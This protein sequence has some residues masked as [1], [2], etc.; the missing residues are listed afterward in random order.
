[1]NVYF[2]SLIFVL[3]F[4]TISFG[5]TMSARIRLRNRMQEIMS[6]FIE[7]HKLGYKIARQKLGLTPKFLVLENILSL[8]KLGKTGILL[9]K[10]K[11][12][13]DEGPFEGSL[14]IKEFSSPEE[15]QK[16]VQINDWLMRRIQNNPRV[17]IPQIFSAGGNF[18]VYEGID[19][20]SFQESTLQPLIKLRLAGNALATFHTPYSSPVNFNRYYGLLLKMIQGLPISEDRKHKLQSFGLSFLY[21]YQ[22][23]YS[24]VNSYGDFHPGNIMLSDDGETAYLI[25]PEFVEGDIGADR[26]E[27]VSNFFVFDAYMEFLNKES[28]NTTFEQINLFLDSYNQFL[29]HYDTSLEQIY[30][31]THWLAMLFHL[32]LVSLLKG[33]VVVQSMK[34]MDSFDIIDPESHGVEEIIQSYRLC[35]YIWNMGI[36]YLPK[37]AFPRTMPPQPTED[38]YLLTWPI[39]GN[40]VLDM[41]RHDSLLKFAF[42]FPVSEEQMTLERALSLFHLK[43]KKTLSNK[44]KDLNNLVKIDI[45]DINSK[46]LVVLKSDWKQLLGIPLH[47]DANWEATAKIL[48][49]FWRKNPINMLVSVLS[50]FHSVSITE[51][52]NSKIFDKKE[53]KIILQDAESLQIIN[54]TKD[55]VTIN[56]Q[57]RFILG[58]PYFF[59][60]KFFD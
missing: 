51:L 46:D 6:E 30:A 43:D 60:P 54:L 59:D 4:T 26:F 16:L 42:N 22:K 58:I 47:Y 44:I 28:L 3:Y 49:S 7:T 23:N 57:W 31:N 37:N 33:A 32:G 2:T 39:I 17:H 35:R 41:C 12:N 1:M 40:I 45:L 15:A 19:G 36:Q 29:R 21:Y 14:A 38:G 11:F 34:N 56:S 50:S 27:D 18:I 13:T 52:E 8:S 5:S 20:E 55:T 24:G 10:V 9:L 25:D 53:L 48:Y